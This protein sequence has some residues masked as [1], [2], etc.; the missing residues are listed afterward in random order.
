[1][2]HEIVVPQIGEAVAELAL[3]EW[4]KNVGETVTKGERLFAIDSDKAVVEVEAVDEGTLIEIRCPEGSSVM[5]N[6]VV[7]V[8]AS[9]KTEEASEQPDESVGTLSVTPVARRVAE[10]LDVDVSHVPGTGTGGRVT[11][12]DVEAFAARGG[13]VPADARSHRSLG[14][15]DGTVTA[16]SPKARSLAARTGV[17]IRTLQGSGV[18][19]MIV[20]ADV[21]AST[22]GVDTAMAPQMGYRRNML[23]GSD[24]RFTAERW[25]GRWR[26]AIAQRMQLSKQMVPH[27]YLSVDV[28]ME[29]AIELRRYCESELCWNRKP[30]FTDIILRACAL[31]LSR[32]P[33]VRVRVDATGVERFDR[34]AVG[35]AV[36]TANGPA[37]AVI[38]DADQKGLQEVVAETQVTVDRVR[39]GDLSSPGSVPRA[40]VVSNLGMYGVDAFQS[41]IDMPDPM[42][43]AVGRI[44]ERVVAYGGAPAVRSVMTVNLSV[45]HRVIDGAPAAV[46]LAGVKNLIEHAFELL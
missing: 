33:D 1:M 45:D 34:I 26:A 10:E 44:A 19:G 25:G 36:Q 17:D 15:E 11:K 13:S 5:P 24:S 37:V 38:P 46:F 21:R 40:M 30:T 43:L 20:E 9:D 3:V 31:S 2:R 32:N 27:F 4:F 39:G 7:G 6:D 41:I 42:S 12:S 28:D 18:R 16:A 35:V 23:P 14:S 8:V 29:R 22:S